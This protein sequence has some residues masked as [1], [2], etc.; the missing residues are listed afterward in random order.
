MN[1]GL[2]ASSLVGH[3]EDDSPAHPPNGH[4]YQP[5]FTIPSAERTQELRAHRLPERRV[6]A[7]SGRRATCLRS[8]A[9]P[10]I[11]A[12]PAVAGFLPRLS[13]VVLSGQ[14]APA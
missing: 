5:Q 8:S 3:D 14:P 1:A 10:T 4:K 12:A 13:A 11:V 6:T 2:D 7:V 9:M